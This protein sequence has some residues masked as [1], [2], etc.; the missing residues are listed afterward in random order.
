MQILGLIGHGLTRSSDLR[1]YDPRNVAPSKRS[2][3]VLP[4]AGPS[5]SQPRMVVGGDGS[6]PRARQDTFG[7]RMHSRPPRAKSSGQ[8]DKSDGV[9]AMRRSMDGG[10]EMSFIPQSGKL[11]GDREEKDEYSGGT[12]KRDRKIERFGAGMEKGREE[13]ELGSDRGGRSRRRQIGRSASK[14]AFRN[15]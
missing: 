5:R 1:Q 8:T 14:N 3:P 11:R 2:N 4:R 10:M 15:R 13:E 9:L 7:S 12:R 6:L